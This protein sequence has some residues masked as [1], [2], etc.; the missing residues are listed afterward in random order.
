ML[1]NLWVNVREFY[2]K[3]LF[4]SQYDNQNSLCPQIK[5]AYKE[6]HFKQYSKTNKQQTPNK[7]TNKKPQ[8]AF[9]LKNAN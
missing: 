5:S 8:A 3:D 2:Y 9:I 4:M 6:S 1:S 7:K